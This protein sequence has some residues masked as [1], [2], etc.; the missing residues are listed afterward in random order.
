MKTIHLI[1]N[2]HLDPVWLWPWQ[3]G[4]DEALATCRSACD[5]LDAHPDLYFS[6]NE[7][8]VYEQVE[9][10]DPALFERI[11]RHVKAGRWEIVGGWWIQPDCN[12]PSEVG[13]QRQIELGRRYFTE[14]FGLFPRVGYNVDSFGHSAALPGLMRAA[15][16][17]RY[18]FTRPQEHEKALP[19][20]VFRWRGF[21]N[22]PEVTAFRIAMSYGIS[23]QSLDAVGRCLTELPEGIEDT[24]CFVGVG[25][26]GGGPTEEMIA[27]LSENRDA[28]PGA[29]M[30]FSTVQKF[31]DAIEP[32]RDRLPLV[33]GELQMHAIGCYSVHRQSKVLV[34]KG[35]HLLRR[36]EIALEKDPRPD[37]DAARSLADGWKQVCLHQFHDTMGGT[38]VP[39]AYEQVHA[40]LGEALSV[41]DRIL[42][43]S[44]RRQVLQLPDDP[45]QRLVFFNASDRPFDGTV[46]AE[47]WLQWGV[48]QPHFRLL[49]EQGQH[50]AHQIIQSECLANGLTRLLFRLKL[51]AGETRIVRLDP[52]KRNGG[53][54][55]AGPCVQV[56]GHRLS[57]P[58]G[59]AL[60]LS[61]LGMTFT[62][63]APTAARTM[64]DLRLPLPSLHLLE[65]R[66]DTWSHGLDR[67]AEGPAV[68]A[69]WNQPVVV[70]RGPLMASVIQT[71][72]IGDSRL[73]AEWRLWVDEPFV[74][75]LL[76]V[77]WMAR[78]RILKLVLPLAQP[79]LRRWDGISVGQIERAV[80]GRELPLL[81]HTR[82]ELEGGAQLGVVCPD[83]Y[84]MDALPHRLRFT[85]LR[86]PAMAHHDPNPGTWP[87]RTIADQ[88]MHDFRFRFTAGQ[89]ASDEELEQAAI[90]MQRPPAMAETTRGMPT[91]PIRIP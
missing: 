90:Q 13:F 78:D 71:G 82:V 43:M 10:L 41:A 81:D 85:L 38:A 34:R 68:S 61:S 24:M 86:S 69:T 20:R 51:G 57:S 8:W 40:Q 54:F 22:G 16:Q 72:A 48:W 1:F 89:S 87:R 50:I 23:W 26:H 65:D 52:R 44:L 73:T 49:D 80:D 79:T 5:R 6:R 30:V 14:K 74:D 9:K 75:L 28:I 42:H 55:S 15:G 70:D 3:A 31:F 60:D 36:A 64:G 29:R 11:H 62:A 84:A 76:R 66:S 37:A 53:S 88:G 59:A 27:W 67:F 91:F 83:V 47:P 33:T 25:D 46:E 32:Q 17:D 4:L 2:A 12:L 58:A 21:E 19:A 7:A 39:S 63:C 18:V 56:T 35:E 45:M 77:H